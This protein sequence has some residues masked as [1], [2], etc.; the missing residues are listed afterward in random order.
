MTRRTSTIVIAGVVV[1]VGSPFAFSATRDNLREG[2]RNPTSDA[3]TSE[4]QIIARV[5]ADTYGTR[6]SNLGDGG[7]AIYGCS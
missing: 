5:G 6:Q 2:V 4:T 3:A 7:A 1:L